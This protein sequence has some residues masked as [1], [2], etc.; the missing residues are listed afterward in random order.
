M[1]KAEYKNMAITF[2]LSSILI[3]YILNLY[4]CNSSFINLIN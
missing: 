1:E 3:T 2:L 4:L